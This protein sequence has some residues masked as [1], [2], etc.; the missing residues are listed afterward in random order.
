MTVLIAH[1]PEYKYAS[2]L[3]IF[4]TCNKLTGFLSVM[5]LHEQVYNVTGYMNIQITLIHITNMNIQIKVIWVT[6]AVSHVTGIQ[7]HLEHEYR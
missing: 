4:I 2:L 3:T 6:G 1:I 5:R 7:E